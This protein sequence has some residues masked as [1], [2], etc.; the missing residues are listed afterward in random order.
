MW[1]KWDYFDFFWWLVL[2]SRKIASDGVCK[3]WNWWEYDIC[4]F[5]YWIDALFNTASLKRGQIMEISKMLLVWIVAAV[6]CATIYSTGYN[7]YHCYQNKSGLCFN[8]KEYRGETTIRWWNLNDGEECCY[9]GTRKIFDKQPA[10]RKSFIV[11]LFGFSTF[12][13]LRIRQKSSKE[14]A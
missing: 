3:F 9:I 2:L 12:S 1:L 10:V 5:N 7:T 6:L 14:K 8:Y 4:H 11:L 13:T